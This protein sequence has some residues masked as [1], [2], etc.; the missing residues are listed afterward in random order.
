MLT[1]EQIA[2]AE[3]RQVAALHDL[4]AHSVS[5]VENLAALKDVPAGSEAA[6][7]AVKAAVAATKIVADAVRDTVEKARQPQT[8]PKKNPSR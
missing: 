4:A 5:S 8:S 6:V 1:P 3:K 2:A 7:Q